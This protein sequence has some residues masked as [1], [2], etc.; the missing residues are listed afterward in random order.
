MKRLVVVV[1]DVR[2]AHNVGSILRTAD[3]MSVEKVYLTGYT[4]FPPAKNDPR[5]PHLRDKIGKKI[6]KTS[7]GAEKSITWAQD[8]DVFKLLRKLKRDGWTIIALEQTTS[9][10]LLQTATVRDKTALVV[11]SEIAGIEEDLLK[12]ADK[13][14]MIPMLGSKESLNVANATAI[15]LYHMR[16]FG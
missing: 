3:A 2:S 11:G 1:H 7:L 16:Y 4:P 14:L 9:A 5:L 13:H 12:L 6:A 8:N 15:A 10:K